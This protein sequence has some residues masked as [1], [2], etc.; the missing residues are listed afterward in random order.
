M[1]HYWHRVLGT[2][3]GWFCNDFSFYGNKV[4]QSV[5]IKIDP[6][7]TDGNMPLN[8]R[9]R[10]WVSPR[11]VPCRPQIR[12]TCTHGSDWIPGN[13]HNL[14]HRRRSFRYPST[15]RNAHQSLSI[16]VLF[17]VVMGS[18]RSKFYYFPSCCR[19]LSRANARHR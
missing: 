4:F 13:I 9:Q 10:L 18:I 15:T 8:C 16:L 7:S 5:L 6:N 1:I 2:A 11:C 12:R 14:R 19:S 3:G 17:L